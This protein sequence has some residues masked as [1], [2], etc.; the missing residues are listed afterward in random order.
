M[1]QARRFHADLI[2]TDAYRGVHLVPSLMQEVDWELVRLSVAPLLIVRQPR[3]YAHPR[4]LAALDPGQNH[5]K[6]SGLDGKILKFAEVFSQALHGQYARNACVSRAG[7]LPRGFGG[8]RWHCCC[9]VSGH[10]CR[11]STGCSRCAVDEHSHTFRTP[12]HPAGTAGGFNCASGYGIECVH[13]GDGQCRPIRSWTEPGR[14]GGR[15]SP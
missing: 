7:R 1:R 9:R 15:R 5:S 10:G 12:P 8:G 6:P 3:P 11:P 14:G 2:V 13:R 4:V